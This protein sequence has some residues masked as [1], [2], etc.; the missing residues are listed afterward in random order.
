VQIERKTIVDGISGSYLTADDLGRAASPGAPG[1]EADRAMGTSN[2]NRDTWRAKT[3]ISAVSPLESGHSITAH[4]A[5][6]RFSIC[7][8][9]FYPKRPTNMA[10][11]IARRTVLVK[12][13]S[14]SV[15]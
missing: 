4:Y 13:S 11:P 15:S 3:A 7:R 1:D 6:L 10:A 5:T 12:P 8:R 9:D 14:T 2:A